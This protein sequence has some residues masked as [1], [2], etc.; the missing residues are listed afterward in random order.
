MEHVGAAGCLDLEMVLLSVSAPLLLE[1]VICWNCNMLCS[2]DVSSFGRFLL[3]PLTGEVRLKI[4][5][6]QRRKDEHG[7]P[8]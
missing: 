1:S 3:P 5:K 7:R 8:A 6:S 2:N 4:K